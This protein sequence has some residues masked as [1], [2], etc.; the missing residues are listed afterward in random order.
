MREKQTTNFLDGNS[1]N[2]FITATKYYIKTC[3]RITFSVQKIFVIVRGV[4][5]LDR[6]VNKE[7]PAAPAGSEVTKMQ[8]WMSALYLAW[9]PVKCIQSVNV[10][11]KV[12]CVQF[13]WLMK[14]N[15]AKYVPSKQV[16]GLHG[17][18]SL[19]PSLLFQE[20]WNL[21]SD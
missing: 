20:I 9:T 15:F 18:N 11:I 3:T 2:N 10:Q 19:H 4:L 5:S 16:Y 14:S 8:F 12:I 13:C 17:W 21:F 6:N 7:N 1:W